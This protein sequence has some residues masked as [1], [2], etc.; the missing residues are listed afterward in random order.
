ME[1][2][3]YGGNCLKITT[4]KAVLVVDDNLKSLGVKPISKLDN[5]SLVTNPILIKA[6]PTGFVI[7]SPG[8]YE[9]LDV[10]IK[11]IG[12]RSHMDEVGKANAVV[13]RVT[14]GDTT[15]AIA[16][17]I[18][19]DLTDDELEAIGLVDVLVVPVG[20][21]GY[22]LDAVGALQ[23]IKKIEPK[24]IIPV[25]YDDKSL[26]YEVPQQSLDEALKALGME[27]FEKVD[28]FKL[29]PNEISD[30]A[31]LVVLEKS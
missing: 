1:L 28:K 2:Q 30:S 31:H 5:V 23:V 7:D 17:H 11:G 19:P 8:E 14:A 18:H 4:K 22:T 29:K 15:I 26:K 9:M 27:P 20:G 24:V 21:N 16:G 10:V 12:V 6:E 3:Y 25:H 13:Y